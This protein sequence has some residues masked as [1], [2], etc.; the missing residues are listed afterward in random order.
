MIMNFI[1][2]IWIE[3]LYPPSI[4]V[5]LSLLTSK[6]GRTAGLGLST[7]SFAF[8]NGGLTFAFPLGG[9]GFCLA[10]LV[11]AWRG[12]IVLRKVWLDDVVAGL[13]VIVLTCDDGVTRFKTG[14]PT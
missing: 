3:K 10:L 8:G 11:H 4:S 12:A 13:A 7:F 9:G 6:P 5:G 14:I 1:G 2:N